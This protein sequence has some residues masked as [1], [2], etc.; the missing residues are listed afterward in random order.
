MIIN[1]N[2]SKL[3]SATFITR[4][5][6]S[7][8]TIAFSW[9][10]Y[11]MTGSRTLMGG[12]FVLSVLPNLIILPFSGVLADI[13]DKKTLVVIGDITRG[14]FVLMMAALYFFD[15]L[16]VWHLFAFVILNN[17]VESFVNPARM[18]MLSSIVEPDDHIKANSYLTSSS[19]FGSMLGIG[20]A[21]VIIGL[22]GIP[23]AF[24]I[25]ALTFLV[26]AMVMFSIAFRDRKVDHKQEHSVKQYLAMIKEGFVY[27]K[28]KKFILMLVLLGAMVNLL[29][30][31][32][33]VLQ[34]VYVDEILNLGVEGLT[35]LGLALMSGLTIGG[36]IMGSLAK[37]VNPIHATGFGLSMMGLMYFFLGGIDFINVSNL[38]V[39]LSAVVL[40]FLFGFCLPIVQAPVN[41]VVM[42][43]IPF[44]MMGRM[45]STFAIFSLSAVPLGGVAVS[46]IGDSISVPV[47]YITAGIILCLMSITFWFFNHK[48]VL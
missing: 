2:Y 30:V 25:D 39:I 29:F 35:Y 1:K 13:I 34:P 47:L 20:V 19:N 43:R 38:T 31:P 37:K 7:I 5:G 48:K 36:V 23:G 44:E 18:S 14:V 9:L 4:F 32:Y 8:D 40:T 42:K 27:L 33:N 41:G 11:V 26:S 15:L 16:A 10:V 24:A 22:L 12:I 46:A 3:I 6:D 28:E 21:G 17:I 45:M